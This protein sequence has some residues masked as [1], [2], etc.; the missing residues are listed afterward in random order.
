MPN[1]LSRSYAATREFVADTTLGDT[2]FF[3]HFSAYV[4]VNL[5]LIA[6]NLLTTPNQ[7]WFYWPLLGWGIGILAHGLAV[8]FSA[9]E[10]VRRRA[11][12]RHPGGV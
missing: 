3:F 10:R 8:K 1:F 12:S 11:R 4:L 9:E 7:L 5:I 6:V 2:G